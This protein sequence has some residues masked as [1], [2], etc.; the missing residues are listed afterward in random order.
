MEQNKNS[1]EAQ[2]I[3]PCAECENAT[4]LTV[5]NEAAIA[6][7][8]VIPADRWHE[9]YM[10]LDELK[11]EIAAGVRFTGYSLDGL[12]IGVMGIQNVRNVR[13]IRHAYVL[14]NYQGRGIGSALISN[15][16]SSSTS[17]MLIGTWTAATWAVVSRGV[18]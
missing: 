10:P 18:V 16:R 1:A 14:P 13:L 11:A 6:Y 2:A 17:P 3:R 8:G 12:L 7:K 9:P 5:I 15:L 4:I